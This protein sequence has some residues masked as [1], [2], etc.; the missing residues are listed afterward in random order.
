MDLVVEEVIEL[1]SLERL[2]HLLHILLKC[3]D[4]CLVFD[5][6]HVLDQTVVFLYHSLL[7]LL[8]NCKEYLRLVVLLLDFLG[9]HIDDLSEEIHAV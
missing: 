9:F 3:L 4:Q 7:L 2:K 8:K 5:P 6:Q 1:K